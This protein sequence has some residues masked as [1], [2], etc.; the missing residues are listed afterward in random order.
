VD[1]RHCGKLFG[2][3]EKLDPSSDGTGV[4]LALVKRIIE[5][6]SGRIWV[7]SDGPGLGTI[8]RFTLPKTRRG[9]A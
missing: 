7:E 9:E 4:G 1:P 3:F 6:H 5:I 8:F 2:L